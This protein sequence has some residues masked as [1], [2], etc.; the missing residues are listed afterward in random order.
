MNGE[1][2]GGD[3]PPDIN[4]KPKTPLELANELFPPDPYA[5]FDKPLPPPP[6]PAA[7]EG[8]LDV[9][10]LGGGVAVDGEDEPDIMSYN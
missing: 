10:F 9:S 2:A 5:R 6:D 4:G 7:G 8:D 1:T 3:E